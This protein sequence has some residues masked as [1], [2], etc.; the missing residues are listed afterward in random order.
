M[1]EA[2]W[3]IFIAA[4]FISPSTDAIL[5]A[6]WM[7]RLSR[8][9]CDFSS[10]RATF[11]AFVPAYRVAWPPIA[12]PTLAERPRR[13]LGM[14]RFCSSGSGGPARPRSL[15]SERRIFT[16]QLWLSPSVL[17][18][19]RS[20]L[21]G[22]LHFLSWRPSVACASIRAGVHS[23]AR[24]S[25][26]R[27]AKS[28]AHGTGPHH[29]QRLPPRRLRHSCHPPPAPGGVGARRRLRTGRRGALV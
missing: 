19:S 12:V 14:L 8:R 9:S 5:R 25:V 29:T 10:E 24:D 27:L 2:I 18:L 15:K 1:N 20:A 6:V 28:Q 26:T 3:P 17:S 21:I 13:D 7:C 23:R 22:S 11:A 16:P 4:P